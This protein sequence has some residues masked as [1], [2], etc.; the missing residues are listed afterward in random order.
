MESVLE[1]SKVKEFLVRTKSELKKYAENARWFTARRK[2][3]HPEYE[4]RFK[5]PNKGQDWVGQSVDGLIC[6][7]MHIIYC[8]VR[9]TPYSAIEVKVRPGNEPDWDC[10]EVI[11]KEDTGLGAE[12]VAKIIRDNRPN[13]SE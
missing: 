7:H 12:D 10:I 3:S 5:V 4:D 2:E 6:R 1:V 11:L 9:G 13:A 8:L